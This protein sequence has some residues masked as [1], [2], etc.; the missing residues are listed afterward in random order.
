MEGRDDGSLWLY[1]LHTVL[2]MLRLQ[3]GRVERLLVVGELSEELMALAKAN[4]VLA[5]AVSGKELGVVLGNGVVHQGVAVLCRPMREGS[6]G[7][8]FELVA[9]AKP[10]GCRTLLMLDRVQDPRNLGACLRVADAAGCL[11]VVLTTHQSAPLSAV[12]MK[13]ASG[14]LLPVFRVSNLVR[15]MGKLK[16]QGF[17]IYGA[18]EGA[19][20]SI[21]DATIH[22][23]A[24]WVMG[25]EG[26]GLRRLVK[27]NCDLL[28]HIP[29]GG[30]VASLNLSVAAGLCLFETARQHRQ[31]TAE[32]S[33]GGG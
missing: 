30:T 32:Q 5:E 23:Q 10:A 19:S 6:E 3:P 7:E 13:A 22:R 31:A 18:S 17:W 12:A 29:M 8:L 27:Q 4:K 20:N 9:G 14:A 28:L 2:A 15:V 24:V 21:Y 25:S 11:G 16:Q 26:Q 33:A 1:G